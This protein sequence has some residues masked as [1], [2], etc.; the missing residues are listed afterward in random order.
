MNKTHK[1][2]GIVLSFM[3]MTFIAGCGGGTTS[4]SSSTDGVL[5]LSI[6]DAPPKL[7][8]NVTGVYISVIGIEYNYDGNWTDA[9]EFV[10]QTFNLLEL[11]NGNSLHLGDFTL[12]P[13]EY[14][15][16]RFKLDAPVEGETLKSNPGCYITYADADPDPLFVPSG[17]TSGYKGKGDFNI[18]ANAQ[19]SV[20][21]DFDVQKSI[22]VAGKSGKYLLKP[23]IRLVVNELSGGIQGTVVDITEYNTTEPE[24]ESLVVYSYLGTYDSSIEENVNVDGIFFSNAI[25]STDVNMTDGNFTLSFLGEGN[26][27]LIT[28]LYTGIAFQNVVDSEDNVEV[29]KG[30]VT[31]VDLN[32]SD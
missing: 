7:G 31:L 2:T 14:S 28:A 10:P 1:I 21:A 25:S 11:Q 22:V 16:I 18:T 30:Q 5:S 9:T 4:S 20:M 24:P 32:T 17:S 26:Y 3:I 23:V 8:E 27:T 6:T 19:I 29:L 12:P 15:E 13:G